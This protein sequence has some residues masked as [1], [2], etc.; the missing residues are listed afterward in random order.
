MSTTHAE[1]RATRRRKDGGKVYLKWSARQFP[2]E[3]DSQACHIR[4]SRLTAALFHYGSEK[5]APR[6]RM[7]QIY[8]SLLFGA[9]VMIEASLKGGENSDPGARWRRHSAWLPN[10]F[11]NFNANCFHFRSSHKGDPERNENVPSMR[12]D[13]WIFISIRHHHPHPA[14]PTPRRSVLLPSL[15]FLFVLLSQEAG[16]A[17][18]FSV[19]F[20]L[21]S[22]NENELCSKPHLSGRREGGGKRRRTSLSTSSRITSRTHAHVTLYKFSFSNDQFHPRSKWDYQRKPNSFL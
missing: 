12:N 4:F 6:N 13:F 7:E 9:F 16:F 2:F 1:W 5:K 18:L 22:S 8:T 3:F 11:R 14:P 17:A 15:S 20:G 21:H 10:I 19:C